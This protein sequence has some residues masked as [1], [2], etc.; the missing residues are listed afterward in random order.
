MKPHYLLIFLCAGYIS[1]AQAEL[2]KKVD[3]DGHVTYFS[4]PTKGSKKIDLE[5]LTIVPSPAH[6]HNNAAPSFKAE[7]LAEDERRNAPPPAPETQ[8]ESTK[9]GG[10][11]SF[12][13]NPQQGY[14]LVAGAGAVGEKVFGEGGIATGIKKA[15]ADGVNGYDLGLVAWST[16]WSVS[17]SFILA[18]LLT[19][20]YTQSIPNTAHEQGMK[21]G[22]WLFLAITVVNLPRFLRT[23]E[24]DDFAN[25]LLGI[26]VFPAIGYGFGYVYFKLRNKNVIPKAVPVSS[27]QRTV[28]IAPANSPA[29]VKLSD[30]ARTPSTETK[31]TM[32]NQPPVNVMPAIA[33]ESSQ[34]SM[35]EIEDRL[36]EQIAQEIETNTVDKGIWTRL[37]AECGGDEKQIKVLYIKQRVEKLIALAKEELRKSRELEELRKSQ[38]AEHLQFFQGC[39]EMHRAA[40]A[41]VSK[42]AEKNGLLVCG[43]DMECQELG[44]KNGD[45]II[46]YNGVDVRN[47]MALFLRQLESSSSSAQSVIRLIRENQFIALSVRGGNLGLKLSQLV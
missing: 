46:F 33:I 44:I 4:T 7:I 22:A 42:E 3:A 14:G 15:G 20:R 47:N 37:F 9:R 41:E 21:W 35:P 13:Q 38:E 24:E 31:P 1:S 32:N 25:L 5:P 12:Q 2:Y 34:Q 45:V 8:W 6:I 23:F 29:V 27:V 39:V 17:I 43:I 40:E 19:K 28:L 11:E 36:Y 10:K 18:I 26:I 30:T 16:L